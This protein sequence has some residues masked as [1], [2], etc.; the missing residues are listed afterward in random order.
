[1]CFNSVLNISN[2]SQYFQ[3]PEFFRLPT[4]P[5]FS[6]FL[7]SKFILANNF[8]DI[9]DK[10]VSGPLAIYST[11]QICNI[12]FILLRTTHLYILC[13]KAIKGFMVNFYYVETEDACDFFNTVLRQKVL[14]KGISKYNR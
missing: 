2:F 13:W 8:H 9:Y 3:F 11:K 6:D 1:M 14:G 4:F 10:F 5:I 12:N 7:T